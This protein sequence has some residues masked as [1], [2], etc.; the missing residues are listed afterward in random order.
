MAAA[1][2]GGMLQQGVPKTDVRIVDVSSQARARFAE[3]GIAAHAK[4]TGQP[5]ADVV[6]FAVKPQQMREA[7]S[8]LKPLFGSSLLISIAAGI[9]STDIARWLGGGARV[10]RAMPNTPALIGAG[11]AGMFASPDVSEADRNIAER[12]VGAAGKVVWFDREQQ[13]DAVT[14]VSGSGPAYVFYFIEALEEAALALDLDAA[15]ART[16]AIETFLGAAQLAAQSEDAPAVLRAKVTSKGGTTQT[17]VASMESAHVRSLVVDAVKQAARRA[18]E[19][20]D[21]FGN[22]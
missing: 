5:G 4:W 12:I 22:E 18:R 15:A 7:V 19:L 2:V 11:V 20:G 17:A 16:L 14:A 21:E 3:M 10:V 13:L 9:R 8:A 1:L 6:V